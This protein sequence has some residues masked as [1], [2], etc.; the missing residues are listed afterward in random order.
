MHYEPDNG[1]NVH[2]HTCTQTYMYTYTF[3]SK[4]HRN[5]F[6]LPCLHFLNYITHSQLFKNFPS[7]CTCSQNG[8]DRESSVSGSQSPTSSRQSVS[9][10]RAGS[11]VS[12]SPSMSIN[13]A[14]VA[15]RLAGLHFFRHVFLSCT[16]NFPANCDNDDQKHVCTY[17]G[18]IYGKKFCCVVFCVVTFPDRP[19][20]E[21]CN[22]CTVSRTK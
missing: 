17:T 8:W 20:L 13:I 18:V 21:A 12:R 9:T 15:Y 5:P 3:S 2:R 16:T 6:L 7:L 11:S 19:G 1:S 22:F 14:L 4:M 10:C